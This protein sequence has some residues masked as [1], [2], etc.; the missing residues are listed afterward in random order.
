MAREP[1]SRFSANS[2]DVTTA[3]GATP[4]T[5]Y[6][7]VIHLMHDTIIYVYNRKGV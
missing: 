6:V 7:H 1:S 5:L 2:T 4:S 3:G